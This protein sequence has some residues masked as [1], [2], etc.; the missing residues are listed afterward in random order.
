[1]A[2]VNIC[3]CATNEY[4]KTRSKNTLCRHS[5]R[6]ISQNRYIPKSVYHCRFQTYYLRIVNR[7]KWFL[8]LFAQWKHPFATFIENRNT[9][10]YTIFNPCH[11]KS[12][13]FRPPSIRPRPT[14][15]NHAAFPLARPELFIIS[16]LE[17]Q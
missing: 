11:V 10:N 15:F 16:H 17:R 3:E 1:M 5:L 12:L 2:D 13:T 4:L 14:Y 9:R 7:R 8:Y 6:T